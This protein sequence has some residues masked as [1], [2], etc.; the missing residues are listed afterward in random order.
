MLIEK[1]LYLPIRLLTILTIGKLNQPGELVKV[2]AHGRQLL[3]G[4]LWPDQ[5]GLCDQTFPLG[6]CREGVSF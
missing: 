3:D 1:L 2:A 6:L 5:M 4:D